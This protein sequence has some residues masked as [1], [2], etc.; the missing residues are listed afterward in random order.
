MKI[1]LDSEDSFYSID[2]NEPEPEPKTKQN[3]DYAGI[4]AIIFTLTVLSIVIGLSIYTAWQI[5]FGAEDN[6]SQ[7]LSQFQNIMKRLIQERLGLTNMQDIQNLQ[8]QYDSQKHKD[9]DDITVYLCVQVDKNTTQR[10]CKNWNND[11]LRP[12]M[13]KIISEDDEL[14][15]LFRQTIQDSF[16]KAFNKSQN[17]SSE[18]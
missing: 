8:D 3:K 15:N 14:N 10:V 7:S 1:Y 12:V 6:Q 18:N 16:D 5:T 9:P 4:G 13:L 11:E 17:Y 2:N